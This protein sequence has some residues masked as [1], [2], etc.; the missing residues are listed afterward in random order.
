MR[1][2]I[3]SMWHYAG[4]AGCASSPLLVAASCI[5]ERLGDGGP[6]HL[7]KHQRAVKSL[8]G[9]TRN[10]ATRRRNSQEEGRRRNSQE[11]GRRRAR[12]ITRKKSSR[13]P[14]AAQLASRRGPP[15]QLARRGPP[16]RRRRNS[17]L[18]LQ[19]EQPRGVTVRCIQCNCGCVQWRVQ[20][21]GHSVACKGVVNIIQRQ[22]PSVHGVGCKHPD[23]APAYSVLPKLLAVGVLALYSVLL[24]SAI[25]R[26]CGQAG[27]GP[28]CWPYA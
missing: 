22:A 11:E 1:P 28:C 21:T 3:T 24:S 18:V 27:L 12:G 16:S 19:G 20:L 4:S 13:P 6:R 2:P 14:P 5:S 10:G 23:C 9:A 26:S 8:A 25:A 15:A 7:S 17:Q